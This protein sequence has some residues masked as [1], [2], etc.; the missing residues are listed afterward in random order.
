MTKLFNNRTFAFV[1]LLGLMLVTAMGIVT[2]PQWAKANPTQLPPYKAISTASTSPVYMLAATSTRTISYDAL[3]IGS[4][5]KFDSA[6]IVGQYTASSSADKLR[7]RVEYSR[8]GI[9]WYPDNTVGL[10]NTF[11]SSNATSSQLI[12]DGA[13]YFIQPATTTVT[14]DGFSG[15]GTATRIHYSIQVPWKAR[16]MRVVYWNR[17]G[18]GNG[19][20]YSEILPI[21]EKY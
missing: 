4:D 20:L 19:A 6:L 11:I 13:N 17:V 5:T 16:W 9:D 2:A 10:N 3:S 14:T 1:S 12:G 21:K 15:S 8:D 18:E 7:L